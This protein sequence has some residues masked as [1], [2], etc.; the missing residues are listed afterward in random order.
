MSLWGD[1]D[2]NAS[3]PKYVNFGQVRGVN[4][5]A[6]GA[7]Y[8]EADTVTFS[9]PASGVQATGTLVVVDGAVVGVNIIDQGAGYK[10]SDN[11]SATITTST[12]SGATLDVVLAPNSVPVSE[13]VFVDLSEAQLESN[14]IKGIK[15]PGWNR[16]NSRVVNGQERISVEPMIAFAR[17]AVD[18][19]DGSD[20]AVVGDAEFKITAQPVT[21]SVFEGQGASFGVTVDPSVGVT[22]QWQVQTGGSGSYANLTNTAP[23]SNTTTATMAISDVTGLDKNRYRVQA[24]NQAGTFY[25]TSRGA[26]LSVVPESVLITSQPLSKSV[27]TATAFTLEVV[28]ESTGTETYQWQLDSGSG[29]ANITNGGVYSGATTATLSVSNS[30]GLTGMQYQVI[31]TSEFGTKTVTSEVAT[32][33]VA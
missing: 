3:K 19:G 24:V 2:N 10:T 27:A 32:I 29:F 21:V 23:Y 17:K 22:Y 7:D 5:T 33:T 1:K 11:V 12:G 13:I 28:A 31:V 6:G 15:T 20:D 26:T 18:A 16:V 30:T 4:V 25:V 9:A 14:R 8:D